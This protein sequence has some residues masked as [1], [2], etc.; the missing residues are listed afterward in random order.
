MLDS[1]AYTKFTKFGVDFYAI[2]SGAKSVMEKLF[3]ELTT[4]FESQTDQISVK[5]IAVAASDYLIRY[6]NAKKAQIGLEPGDKKSE[7]YKKWNY[8]TNRWEQ[9]YGHSAAFICGYENKLSV[10]EEEALRAP[11]KDHPPYFVLGSSRKVVIEFM[12]HKSKLFERH[13]ISFR[14]GPV[15]RDDIFDDISMELA[16]AVVGAAVVDIHT[17]GEVHVRGICRGGR[18]FFFDCNVA[19]VYLESYASFGGLP[20][21][22]VFVP[23][24]ACGG[25]GHESI[26]SFLGS[27]GSPKMDLLHRLGSMRGFGMHVITFEDEVPDSNI[28]IIYDKILKKAKGWGKLGLREVMMGNMAVQVCSPRLNPK[29]IGSILEVCF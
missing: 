20:D 16:R 3:G 25:I 21:L 28:R 14:G 22:L 26:E 24:L 2:M 10:T 9:R 19:R 6:G 29:D 7:A 27:L 8:E 11:I 4:Y 17:G 18:T 23:I 13:R 1:D 12:S 15:R 5:D